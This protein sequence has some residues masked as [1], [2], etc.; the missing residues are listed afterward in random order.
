MGGLV[1]GP[2]EA[3]EVECRVSWPSISVWF[4]QAALPSMVAYEHMTELRARG[5]DLVPGPGR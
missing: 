2:D 1:V 3:G 5:H 4:W